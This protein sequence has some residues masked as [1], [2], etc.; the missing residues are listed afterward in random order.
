MNNLVTRQR[1]LEAAGE[2]FADKG[3][4]GATIRAICKRAGANVAAVKYH[5]G[6]KQKL[7]SAVAQYAHSQ[8][9]GTIEEAVQIPPDATAEQRVAVFARAML[10]GLLA[11]GKPAW[12]GKLM[13]R[14]MAEPTGALKLIIDER[15]RPRLKI[16]GEI[17]RSIL[18]PDVP[19]VQVHRCA[20]SIVGQIM[21]YHFARPV[22]SRMFPDEKLDD[23][24]V[25]ALAEHI[26]AFSV[27]G[28]AELAKQNREKGGRS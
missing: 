25:D 7:Y 1:L 16:L 20:R 5:F 12:H 22:I 24:A 4:R 28:L 11:S 18:G 21:F 14:E 26:A 3:F 6:D 9:V 17:V 23:S 10:R 2:V 19:A 13:A 15:I 27:G 8:G